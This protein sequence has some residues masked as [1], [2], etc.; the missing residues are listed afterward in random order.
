M[1]KLLLIFALLI[2]SMPLVAQE[3]TSVKI[4]T[5]KAGEL[6]ALVAEKAATMESLIVDGPLNDDD[7]R[8]MW[9]AT[10]KGSLTEI[11]MSAA[12]L[13]DNR[14]PADAFYHLDEQQEDVG[15][16]LPRFNTIKLRIIK[17]PATA[18]VIGEYSFCD[19]VFLESVILPTSLEVIGT[20]SFS[21]CRKLTCD[22]LI[23]PEGLRE[24]GDFAFEGCASMRGDIELPSTLKTIGQRAFMQCP[25]DIT[26]LPDGLEDIGWL[27]FNSTRVKELVISSDCLNPAGDQFSSCHLLTKVTIADGIT[28]L[29]DNCFYNCSTLAQI[30]LPGSIESIGK[31][32]FAS[33]GIKSLVL[34]EGVREIKDK[35]F[36]NCSALENIIFPSTLGYLGCESCDNWPSIKS[37]SCKATTPPDCDYNP[38]VNSFMQQPF[39]NYTST[40]PLYVPKGT[41][42]LYKDT[43][44]WGLFRN[45]IETEDFPSS[46]IENVSAENLPVDNT[47]YDLSGRRVDNPVK[48]HLYISA[49]KKLVW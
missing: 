16:Y 42:G 49:G 20:A 32:A 46:G 45:I 21:G 33:C 11:D 14:L 18:T 9:E 17:L 30:E 5:T 23:F 10:F 25:I 29:P 1:K 38:N 41:A 15:E 43:P 19:A 6:E 44:A 47:L 28:S 24:I 13:A 22:N 36:E 8:F 40:C 37:I 35:A 12:I 3:S 34:P 26:A 48:G 7:I 2:G 4:S 31:E 27:A 39:G